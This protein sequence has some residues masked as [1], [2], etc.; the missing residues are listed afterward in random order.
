M[1]RYFEA[2]PQD[3]KFYG[4]RKGR[5]GQLDT[6]SVEQATHVVEIIRFELA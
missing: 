1:T 5:D 6:A 2:V 4:V 3:K